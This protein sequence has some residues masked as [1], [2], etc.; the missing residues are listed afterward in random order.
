MTT[1][2]DL[3]AIGGGSGGLAVCKRAAAHGAKTAV[4]EGGRLG[5]A[6]VN[7]GCV[8][9]KV[10]WNGAHLAQALQDAPDYGFNLKA[11]QFSWPTLKQ[12]RDHYV[13]RLNTL[14]DANLSKA[15]V[16]LIRGY[17]RF[18]DGHTVEVDGHRFSA[19]HIVITTGGRPLVPNIPGAELGI[20]SDGF[21]ELEALPRKVAVVGGG[22]IGV[23]IAGVLN[24][25]GSQV[26][27]LLRSDEPLGAFD[28][29][30]RTTLKTQMIDDGIDLRSRISIEDITLSEK[31]GL[32]V[33]LHDGP[34]LEDFDTLIWAIGRAPNSDQLNIEASGVLRDVRGFIPT[35]EYQNTNVAGIY[36][37]GDVTGRAALTPV[38]IAAG[39]R[40][41]DRLFGNQPHSRLD[42]HNI[43]TVVFSHPPIGSIGLT[44][45]QAREAHGE[46]VKIYQTRFTPMYHALTEH[47]TK[48]AMKLICAGEEEKIVGC[49]IIG[50][51]ADEML[52]GFAVAINMGATK[53]D[54]DRTVA[55]HPT[56]SEELVTLV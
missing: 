41:A 5:G 46:Q 40:L 22:Y 28:P 47:K 55:I 36:A 39:R 3:I 38:A 9:K 45:T 24:A 53:A 25:L 15:G 31:G 13:D 34:E 35:D 52:Q 6:C 21:F 18:I 16:A 12:K 23:E 26:S 2:Y 30:I 33:V 48:T 1:H 49:H 8:P 54:F 19:D 43:A 14:H 20:T 17:A 7:V 11:P 50:L 51:G 27:L 29:L 4:I 44:E 56:S 37:I 10:M 42:Y 32:S